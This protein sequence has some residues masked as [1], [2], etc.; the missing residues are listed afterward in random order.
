LTAPGT[1]KDHTIHV[2]PGF[3]SYPTCPG[4]A[5]PRPHRHHQ[6]FLTT[7]TKL[8]DADHDVPL[9]GRKWRPFVQFVYLPMWAAAPDPGVEAPFTSVT[10]WTWEELWHGDRVLSV[11]KRAAYLSYLELP[12]VVGR[13]FELAVNLHPR[14]HTGDR[15]LLRGPGGA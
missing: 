12:E 8:G 9:L 13:P 10:Q 14:D 15:E 11:G 4:I 6:T 7:G 2:R 1:P 5:R 3:P